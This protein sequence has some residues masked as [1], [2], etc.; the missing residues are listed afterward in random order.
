MDM[1]FLGTGGAWGV[2]EVNCHCLICR[3][4]RRK[5]EKRERTSLLLTDKATLLIDCG[6][7][8]RSQ[9]SRQNI[10]T[11]DGV[12]ITHE[13][14][15][16]YIGLDELFA[17]KRN[18]PRGSFT[19]IPIYLT[20]RSHEVII[21]RFDY[22]EEME[23]IRMCQIDPGQWIRVKEF[24]ILPFDTYHGPFAKGSVGFLV[25]ARGRSGKDVR[26]V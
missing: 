6:P 4:M 12:L 15:D 13:H 2:P 26:I 21:K 24:E 23:V 25:K 9:I 20:A 10:D 8:A 1:T 7:D 18:R 17:Y 11:I 3:D 14:T 22:L 16:H 5:G 19:P